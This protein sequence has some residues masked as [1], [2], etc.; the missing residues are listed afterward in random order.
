MS[1]SNNASGTC[2]H[3]D[4]FMLDND[5]PRFYTIILLS[6]A[7]KYLQ[8]PLFR[9][10]ASTCHYDKPDSKNCSIELSYHARQECLVCDEGC[11]AYP[12]SI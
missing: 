1:E 12:L 5:T 11:R 8:T 6:N 3:V 10:Y 2:P 4:S 7:I 9:L